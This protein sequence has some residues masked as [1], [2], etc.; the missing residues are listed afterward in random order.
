MKKVDL[1]A[2]VAALAAG[3]AALH[4]FGQAGAEKP[5]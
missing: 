1:F 3:R 2:L 4:L 5:K